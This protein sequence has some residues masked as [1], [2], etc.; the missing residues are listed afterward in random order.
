MS[1]KPVRTGIREKVGPIAP[2]PPIDEYAKG[3]A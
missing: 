1:N 3:F 2:L